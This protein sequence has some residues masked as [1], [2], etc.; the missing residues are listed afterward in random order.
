MRSVRSRSLR[1]QLNRSLGVV[2]IALGAL[3]AIVAGLFAY[4]LLV[5]Q[6][7]LRDAITASRQVRT[8][9]QGMIDQETG[10]GGYLLAGPVAGRSF[11]EPYDNGRAAARDG[12]AAA[13]ATLAGDG[14][15]EE[16]LAQ[17]RARALAWQQQWAVP[18][19]AAHHLVDVAV[20]EQRLAS[21]K[22]L[23]DRYRT[24]ET[25]LVRA[26]TA[27]TDG[28]LASEREV[29]V[30]ALATMALCGLA[31]I[32]VLATQR[33]RLLAGIVEP[34][35]DLGAAVH[36]IRDGDL[37]GSISARRDE[38]PAEIEMLW[39]DFV[40]ML[41]ALRM[42]RADVEVERTTLRSLSEQD[43]LTGLYNRRRLTA[44]WDREWARLRQRGASLS[45]LMAD[46]DHFKTFNDTHGHQAGDRLLAA[47]AALVRGA[48]R[49]QD[50]VYRF[51]G[52][53][54]T[55]LVRDVSP[56]EAADMAE[57]V[58]VAVAEQ[59]R[60]AGVT[61]SVGVATRDHVTSTAEIVGAADTALYDAKRAGR[62][63]VVVAAELPPPAAPVAASARGPVVEVGGALS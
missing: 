22:E 15:L 59:L 37:A 26:L 23:F 4:V 47:V 16:L 5:S 61:L 18:V 12:F 9:H 19:L 11:L 36:R 2:S 45:V 34:V 8:A 46:I 41:D 28:E 35:T 53:E 42:R 60:D 44:D 29:I 21:G 62:N 55:V 32:G 48:V 52:E 1:G 31:G 63:R 14:H 54:F 7:Q 51:G 17:T 58:R 24:S 40:D 30:G 43:A 50:A 6:P 27:N 57:R 49:M 33:R 20:D 39:D 56:A 25:R 38:A 3:V 13:E 10:V